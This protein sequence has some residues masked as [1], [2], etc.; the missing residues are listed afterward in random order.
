MLKGPISTYN[1]HEADSFPYRINYPGKRGLARAVPSTR[2]AS[3]DLQMMW[4][5]SES[6]QLRPKMLGWMTWASCCKIV[7]MRCCK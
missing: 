6:A 2:P 5:L 7:S 3:F 1:H 4:C